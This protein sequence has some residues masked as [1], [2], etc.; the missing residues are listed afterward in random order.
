MKSSILLFTADLKPPI[1]DE[2]DLGN[3]TGGFRFIGNISKLFVSFE[4][5]GCGGGVDGENDAGWDSFSNSSV[6][7]ISTMA[8]K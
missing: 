5:N 3:R 4:G 6:L 8:C 7:Q 1:N 2:I